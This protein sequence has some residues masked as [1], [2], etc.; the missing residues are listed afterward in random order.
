MYLCIVYSFDM[1]T[2][3]KKRNLRGRR[4]ALIS[5]KASVLHYESEEI[6]TTKVCFLTKLIIGVIF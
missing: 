3:K 2:T 5:T 4:L 6:S 1:S